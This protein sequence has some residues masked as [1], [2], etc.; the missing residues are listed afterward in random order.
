MG[1]SKKIVKIVISLNVIFVICTFYL[2]SG[3]H[4]VPDSLIVTWFG[5]TTGELWLLAG[6]KK[7]KEKERGKNDE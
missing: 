3:D 6:I 2:C 7:T 1:F 4:I 5:F